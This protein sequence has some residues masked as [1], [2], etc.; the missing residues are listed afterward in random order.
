M[1]HFFELG[2]DSASAVRMVQVLGLPSER[3]NS[4][5]MH[6]RL[7]GLIR[8]PRLREYARWNDWVEC[9]D[10]VYSEQASTSELQIE[11]RLNLPTELQS[12]YKAAE[13]GD[14]VSMR[15]FLAGGVCPNGGIDRKDHGVTPLM[16]ALTVQ[17]FDRGTFSKVVSLLLDARADTN[18]TTTTQKSALL[19]S[20][21]SGTLNVHIL[22]LLLAAGAA[23]G[24]KDANRLSPLH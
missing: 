1:S 8:H 22:D 3:G 19:L 11:Q 12:F 9:K 10:V 5:I 20:A 7:C 16:V 18:R 24:A 13:A 21:E 14:D 17:R 15:I 6:R 23:I 2:G 4:E